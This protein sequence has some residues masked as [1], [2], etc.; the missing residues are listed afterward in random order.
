MGHT[1]PTPKPTSSANVRTI[2]LNGKASARRAV[3]SRPLVE[4]R[5]VATRN[6][7]IAWLL[8]PDLNPR[9]Q[10]A[11]AKNGDPVGL[12]SVPIK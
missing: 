5:G 11:R 4:A 1:A 3:I 8:L 2:C 12:P 7:R 6:E 10:S 9:A